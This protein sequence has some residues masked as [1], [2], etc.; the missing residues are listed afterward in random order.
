[1]HVQDTCVHL[2]LIWFYSLQFM[3][4]CLICLTSL[5]LSFEMQFGDT[6][7]FIQ[8]VDDPWPEQ[9]HKAILKLWEMYIDTKDGRT[10]DAINYLEK[11]FDYEDEITQ[12]K[13]EL[14]NA[15]E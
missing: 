14:S 2:N 3:Y 9:C 7:D 12:L 1:M 11:K 10:H 5:S 8:W 4:C 13:Q 15:Q 6:C